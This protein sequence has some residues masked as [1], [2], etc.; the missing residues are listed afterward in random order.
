MWSSKVALV[1]ILVF[2]LGPLGIFFLDHCTGGYPLALLLSAL[3]VA[4]QRSTQACGV[5]AAV[6]CAAVLARRR[7]WSM[8]LPLSLSLSLVSIHATLDTRFALPVRPNCALSP[9]LQEKGGGQKE[10]AKARGVLRYADGATRTA[11]CAATKISG[12]E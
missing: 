10:H 5:L 9:R 12:S 7:I 11:A 1:I 3:S 4:L 6:C 2:G 8:W